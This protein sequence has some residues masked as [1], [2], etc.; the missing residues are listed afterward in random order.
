MRRR[1]VAAAESAA[2]DLQRVV[3]GVESERGHGHRGGAVA[4]IESECGGQR[5]PGALLDLRFV[6]IFRENQ[7]QHEAV[8]RICESDA[9]AE[10]EFKTVLRHVVQPPGNVYRQLRRRLLTISTQRE[11]PRTPK[12]ET[13]DLA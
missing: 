10:F 11:I 7:L 6:Q 1:A 13:S 8:R 9:G 2:A 4:A 12:A 3:S 5:D